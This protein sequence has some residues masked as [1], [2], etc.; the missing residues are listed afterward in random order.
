MVA[1]LYLSH[2]TGHLSRGRLNDYLDD[3][4]PWMQYLKPLKRPVGDY[5]SPMYVDKKKR[6]GLLHFILLEKSGRVVIRPVQ[7]EKKVR[8]AVSFMKRFVNDR[9][10]K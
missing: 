4:T 8:E 10:R 5:L 1:A 3:L 7:S 2:T 6:N 9:G